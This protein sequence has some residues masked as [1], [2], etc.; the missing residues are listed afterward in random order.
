[1]F[2]IGLY[3]SFNPLKYSVRYVML[4]TITVSHIKKEKHKEVKLLD[5]GGTM[6]FL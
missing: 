3:T 2:I 4:L 6:R 5:Q 1:M